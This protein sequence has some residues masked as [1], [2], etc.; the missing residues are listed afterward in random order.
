VAQRSPRRWSTR[1]GRWMSEFGVRRLAT[2]LKLRNQPTS[3]KAIHEWIAGRTAPT[4]GRAIVISEISGG[5]IRP[6]DI[7]QHGEQLRD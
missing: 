5:S 4:L 1:F 7:R 2:E 3:A 6:E